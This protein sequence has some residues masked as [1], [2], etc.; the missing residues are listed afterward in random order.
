MQV[1]SGTVASL[2][3]GLHSKLAKYRHEIFVEQLGW[4][5]ET[6][7]R[8]EL[9]QFDRLDTVYVIARDEQ[10]RISG[11][12]RLLPTHRPY[13]LGDVFPQLLNGLPIPQS[14]E[15]WELSRFAA[16]DLHN[17]NSATAGQFSSPIALWLL[18]EAIACATARGAKR[19]ISVSPV[20]VERLLR[21][22]GVHAHRAGPPLVI[23][24]D[25]IFAC[26]IELQPEL[27]ETSLPR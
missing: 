22:A 6:Q 17:T 18:K 9:D 11:C 15:I 23:N 2:P 3:A 21:K 1:I 14:E 4:Q 7:D 27:P 19:L 20:G 12:A 8:S 10:R 26:W 25:A 13:L 24:G 16:V 5:L